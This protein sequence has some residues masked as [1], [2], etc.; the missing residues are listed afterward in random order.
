M[1]CITI[2]DF[3]YDACRHA[4][5]R[6]ERYLH[7]YPDLVAEIRLDL[8]GLNE[9]DTQR[10][11]CGSKVPLIATCRRR[12]SE[13]YSVAVLSGA[14]FIDIDGIQSDADI[15]QI[16]QKLKGHKVQKILSY[17]NFQKTPSLN[18]LVSYFKN[19]VSHGAD[20]VKIT[21]SAQNTEDTERL[22][23]LYTLQRSG[24]LDDNVRLVAN[25]M[26]YAGSYTSVEAYSMG[27][28]FLYC[29]LNERNKLYPGMLD[30][31]TYGKLRLNDIVDGSV[32]IPGSK[33]ITQKAIVAS[34]L[35]NGE[36]VL[37]NFSPCRDTEAALSLARK[38]GR[39][40]SLKDNELTVVGQGLKGK[41]QT[42]SSASGYLSSLR[43]M[44]Y[45]A[46]GNTSF[47]EDSCFV[48]ESGLLA[49]LCI[50]LVAQ[51][52]HTGT[53]SG[54][55]RLLER[56][57]TGCRDA[58]EQ[59]GASCI[60][61]SDDTLPAI[62]NG[63]LTG[64][65][66]TVSAKE[67]T[68][69]ISGLLMAL[70]LSKKDSVLEVVDL[71][72]KSNL[73]QTI[74]IIRNFGIMLSYSQ[75]DGK[76]VFNIPGHQKYSPTVMELEG[77]WSTAAN[78]IV[79]AA[80]FGSLKLYGLN[81]KSTQADRAIIDIVRK[82]GA[83][84]HIGRKFIEVRRGHLVAFEFDVT[85]TPDLFPILVVLASYCEGTSVITGLRNIKFRQFRRIETICSELR[86]MGVSLSLT[87]E[88][89]SVKG[90]C[91]TRRIIGDSLLR[92][93]DVITNGDHRVAMALKIAGIHTQNKL[94]VDNMDCIEKS[95][96]LFRDT[97]SSVTK[98][99]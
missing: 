10:L 81:P 26:G 75:E 96:P 37:K 15:Q 41:N 11:F 87:D 72:N 32:S 49:R 78:F 22:L 9:E 6:C 95:Y 28:P 44:F 58:L 74:D 20:I 73:F 24:Q 79:A 43:S 18:E 39:R 90:M 88:E 31:E 69:T 35:S 94:S 93:V 7:T 63:P 77:D 4:L 76:M 57:M 67:G 68:Q 80:I 5:R 98:S 84:V 60:L 30:I 21:T 13:L 23:S 66:A 70:P 89:V 65:F 83:S 42:E 92:G 61:T 59:F 62:I 29:T 54:E 48:G 2:C 51:L 82:T 16:L 36:N 17:Q 40:V 1:I 50:P 55:G 86:E 99:K 38:R 56:E 27:A 52:G 46:S 71:K 33:D 45:G 47:H 3:G 25:A 64:T 8:C 34:L 53:V 91:I 97:L 12:S 19:G 14:S 85:D